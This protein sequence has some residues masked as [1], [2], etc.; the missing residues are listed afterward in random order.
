M[1]VWKLYVG[2]GDCAKSGVSENLVAKELFRGKKIEMKKNLVDQ[3]NMSY[4]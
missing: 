1:K 4:E 3:M 2:N